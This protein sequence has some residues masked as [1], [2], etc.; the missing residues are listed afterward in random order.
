MPQYLDL[1]VTAPNLATI[2]DTADAAPEGATAVIPVRFVDGSVGLLPASQM[3]S[4]RSLVEYLWEDELMSYNQEFEDDWVDE[5]VKQDDEDDH[6]I[7]D[8]AAIRMEPIDD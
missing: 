8:L 5:P 7:F 6:I 3:E 1:G 2:H 4:M